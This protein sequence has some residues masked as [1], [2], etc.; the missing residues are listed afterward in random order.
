MQQQQNTVY[1]GPLEA[2]HNLLEVEE[3]HIFRHSVNV[4]E[5]Q[6]T[7]LDHKDAVQSVGQRCF[8]YPT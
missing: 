8:L 4:V 1:E 7:Q 6:E 2:C 5:T 3:I